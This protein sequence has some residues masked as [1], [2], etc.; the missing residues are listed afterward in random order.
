MVVRIAGPLSLAAYDRSRSLLRCGAE[1]GVWACRL[2]AVLNVDEFESVFRSGWKKN[3]VHVPPSAKRVL[4]VSDLE[5]DAQ[6]AYVQACRGLLEPLTERESPEWSFAPHG[7]WKGVEGLLRL[8]E[9]ERPDVIVTYRNLNSD[10]WKWAYSLGVYLGALT[11][12]TEIPVVVTPNPHAYPSLEWQHSKTDSV[13]VLNDTLVGDDEL[14][15]WG[16][17]VTREQGELHLCHM[18]HDEVFDRYI[19]AI[20]KIPEIDT[21]TARETIQALLMKEP[22]EYIASARAALEAIA[23]PLT[24]HEHV[25]SG[26]R[27]AD[28]RALVDAHEVDLVIFPTLE[29]DRIALHGVAYSLSVELVTTP[30]LMV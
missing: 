7:Q 22:R 20:S 8:V 21:D 2:C 28:Y 12:G 26:H 30:L 14:V 1:P 4:V 6:E 10:A 13:M 11:R 25:L 16:A 15:S 24:I 27:V 9:E 3:F 18:E 23:A 19:D 29:E 17:L 5:A